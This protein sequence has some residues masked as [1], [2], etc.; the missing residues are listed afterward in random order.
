MDTARS[1]RREERS[2]LR[3]IDDGLHVQPEKSKIGSTTSGYADT[4]L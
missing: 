2:R 4:K 3:N 1:K